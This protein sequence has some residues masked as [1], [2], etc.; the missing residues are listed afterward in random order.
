MDS[1]RIQCIDMSMRSTGW[2]C[3]EISYNENKLRRKILDYGRYKTVVPNGVSK[4]HKLEEDSI[5]LHNVIKKL[6]RNE[7]DYETN[8]TIIELPSIS[9]SATS[10]IKIGML[11]GA[12]VH[13]MTD[14]NFITVEETALKEWSNSKRGDGKKTVKEKVMSVVGLPEKAANNSDIVDAVGLSLMFSD[15]YHESKTNRQ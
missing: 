9:Q 5:Q 1:L 2:V 4:F 13:R 14:A 6:E 15:L 11:W 8:V 10:A 3:M 7:K 12:W